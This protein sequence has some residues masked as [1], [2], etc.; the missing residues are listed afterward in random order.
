MEETL[1]KFL[2]EN[3]A[4]W[5]TVAGERVALHYGDIQVEHGHLTESV[6]LIDLTARGCLLHRRR[7]EPNRCL[8]VLLVLLVLERR[9]CVLT[10]CVRRRSACWT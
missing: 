4:E 9:L 10:K 8:L 6:A 1:Q 3:G 7:G 2:T 5:G